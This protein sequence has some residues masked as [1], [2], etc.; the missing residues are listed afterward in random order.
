PIDYDGTK[1][2]QELAAKASINIVELLNDDWT[3]KPKS[4]LTPEQQAHLGMALEGIEVVHKGSAV[5]GTFS[6]T[7]KP[8]FAKLAALTELAKILGMYPVAGKGQNADASG[9]VLQLGVGVQVN[10]EGAGGN[11]PPTIDVGG[12]AIH[13]TKEE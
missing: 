9:M 7:V 3:L 5:E 2:V 10:V 1:V 11:E 13:T 4:A 8:K 6:A 12:L